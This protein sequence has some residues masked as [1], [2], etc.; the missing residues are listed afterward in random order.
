LIR[1]GADIS[2]NK[3]MALIRGPKKLKGAQVMSTDIRA[4]ASLLI[5]ALIAEGESEISRIYHIDRGYEKIEEKFKLLG[6][7]IRR[8][9]G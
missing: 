7:D 3:N 4:S 6:A 5:G 1:L 2:L 9:N 8:E